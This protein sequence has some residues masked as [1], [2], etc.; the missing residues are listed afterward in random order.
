MGINAFADRTP[1]EKRQMMGY[2][3]DEKEEEA[4]K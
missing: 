3:P 2:I 4:V 1:E